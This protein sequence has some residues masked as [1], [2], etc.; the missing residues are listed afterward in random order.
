VEVLLSEKIA[1][2]QKRLKVSW[3]WRPCSSSTFIP[4]WNSST[5]KG[6][7]DQSIPISSP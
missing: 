1:G 7:R 4:A 5:S 2:Q 6:A 3:S